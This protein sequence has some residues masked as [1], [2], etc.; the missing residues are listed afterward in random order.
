MVLM[1]PLLNERVFPE[2]LEQNLNFSESLGN[3]LTPLYYL[4]LYL[5]GSFRSRLLRLYI[6]FDELSIILFTSKQNV[7]LTDLDN[8]TLSY[9]L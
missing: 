5:Y 4:Y 8:K 2:K 6:F 3:L 9:F 7:R 1:Y